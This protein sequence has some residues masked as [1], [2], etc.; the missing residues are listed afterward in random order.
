MNNQLLDRLSLRSRFQRFS[1]GLFR[2]GLA[3]GILASAL[4]ARERRFLCHFYLVNEP[5]SLQSVQNNYRQISLVSPQW[6]GVDEAGQ[7]ESTVD[8]EVVEWAAAH[9][10]PIMPLLINQKFQ[11]SVA[12]A[13]LNNEQTWSQVIAQLVESAAVHR[14][15][16]I[17]VDFEN[18]PAEDRDRFTQFISKLAKEL[19]RRRLKLSVA[20]AAPLTP[21]PPR[22]TSDTSPPA[23]WSAN[24]QSVAYDY[25]ALGRVADFV[26]LMTYDEFTSPDRAGPVAGLPWVIACLQHTLEL[27]PSKKL[28]LGIP[29]YYGLWDGQSVREGP[30]AEALSLAER[31]GTK[32]QVDPEQR[33]EPFQFQDGPNL[34]VVWLQDSQSLRERMAL[35][36]Q[37]RLAGFSAWRLGQEAAEAWNNVFPR[38]AGKP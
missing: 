4:T 2:L 17:Q 34:S 22:T 18:V 5:S 19:H 10:I 6:F 35:V 8:P 31:W 20:T 1:S 27:I 37:Y 29:L 3:L 21:A 26:T 11:P 15:Y 12:H 23:P 28:L 33:E 13:V 14:F 30:Y 7:L 24:N 25:R 9:R 32:I 38:V 36:G 16:G